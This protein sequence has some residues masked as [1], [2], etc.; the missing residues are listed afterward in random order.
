[1]AKKYRDVAHR[2]LNAA[3]LEEAIPALYASPSPLVRKTVVTWAER[4]GVWIGTI[5]FNCLLKL[6]EEEAPLAAIREL[7]E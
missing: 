6:I 3:P 7:L 4:F 5:R 1:L 2:P